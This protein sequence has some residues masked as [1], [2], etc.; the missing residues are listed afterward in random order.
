[1]KFNKGREN[2]KT[3]KNMSP[4]EIT[5]SENMSNLTTIIDNLEEFIPPAPQEPPP[6]LPNQGNSNNLYNSNA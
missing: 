5:I 3:R 2:R 6:L 1:V 4:A